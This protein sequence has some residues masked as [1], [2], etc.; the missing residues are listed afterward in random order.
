VVTKV[1]KLHQKMN[2]DFREI[3]K[4]KMRERHGVEVET[5][6]NF[7]QGT[8]ATTRTDGRAFTKGQHAWL[9]A[10]SDGFSEALRIV[11][12]AGR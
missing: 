8:V 7:L 2:E 5:T 12:E 6:Y 10:F 3:L 11:G 9:A 4:T 1:Q